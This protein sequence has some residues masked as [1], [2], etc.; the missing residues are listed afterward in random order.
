MKRIEAMAQ[1]TRLC[2]LCLLAT[3]LAGCSGHK[4]SILTYPHENI[5]PMRLWKELDTA[6]SLNNRVFYVDKGETIPLALSME[7]DFM[8]FKQER[9]DLVAK[10]RLYF[11][12]RIPETLSASEV[13]EANRIDAQTLSRW[14]DD[15]KRD[16]FKKYMLYISKDAVHWAPISSIPALREVLGYRMGTV[17]FTMAA[18]SE[19]GVGASLVVRTVR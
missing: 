1:C 8:A 4:V 19:H 3:V 12:V 13:A 17:S 7:S 18:G 11:R 2:V 15:D 5:V 10:Q 16:F 14:S 9:I 6:A